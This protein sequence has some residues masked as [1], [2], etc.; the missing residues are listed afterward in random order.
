MNI[1]NINIKT[2][3]PIL[4]VLIILFGILIFGFNPTY[5]GNFILLGFL[6]GII[7]YLLFSYF[8]YHALKVIEDQLPI[9]LLDL[10]ET[11]KTGVT[12][13]EAFKELSNADYSSLTPHIKAVANQLSWG[14]T[15][16]E[17]LINI[18][19]R[20]KKSSLVKEVVRIII[21]ANRAGG[22]LIRT[23][24]TTANDLLVLRE[25]EKDKKSMLFQQVMVMYSIYFIFIA[26]IIAL[27]KTLIPML[28]INTQAAGAL[29]L[30]AFQDPCGLCLTQPQAYCIACSIYSATCTIFPQLGTGSACYY[31][32]LFILMAIIQGIFSGLVAGQIGENSVVAGI[33]HSLIMTLSGFAII[34]I[35]LFMGQM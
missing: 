2:I 11:Q 26:I 1:K 15:L 10:A 6:I 13:A 35:L 7:P 27:S 17:A 30:F 5:L 23:L 12:V 9:F 18:S 8:E 31:R 33:K 16:E 14:I 4:A 32:A 3:P 19:K 34:L 22:D 21:E 28:Q 20:L 25:I 24:E 29:S